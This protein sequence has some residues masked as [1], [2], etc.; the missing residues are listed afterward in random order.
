MYV[1]IQLGSMFHKALPFF[2]LLSHAQFILDLRLD[3][4]TLANS[5]LQQSV[6]SKEEKIAELETKYDAMGV[7]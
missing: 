1:S 6:K 3:D 5:K 7:S 4:F 2:G